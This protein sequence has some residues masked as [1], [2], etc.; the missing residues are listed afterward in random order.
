[1]DSSIV[2]MLYRLVALIL[3]YSIDYILTQLRVS[4]TDMCESESRSLQL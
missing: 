2:Y 4:P 3:V 1:M